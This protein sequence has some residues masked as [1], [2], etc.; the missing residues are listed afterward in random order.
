MN[1]GSST[2]SYSGGSSA[3]VFKSRLPEA[4]CG[5]GRSALDLALPFISLETGLFG[6]TAGSSTAVF[7]YK[8]FSTSLS[9][10]PGGFS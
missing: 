6:E 3:S 4:T 2:Y 9:K 5:K 1:G 7:A 10:L 8:D